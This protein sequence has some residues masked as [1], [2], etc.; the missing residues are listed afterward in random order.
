MATLGLR[1]CFTIGITIILSLPTVQTIYEVGWRQQDLVQPVSMVVEPLKLYLFIH[2]YNENDI[3]YFMDGDPEFILSVTGIFKPLCFNLEGKSG[4]I[5][6]LIQDGNTDISV[7]ARLISDNTSTFIGTVS[8][9][10]K[11]VIII[12]KPHIIIVNRE[13]F[14]WNNITAFLIRGHRVVI[15]MN[16]I[17]VTFRNLNVTAIVKRHETG[18][19]NGIESLSYLGFYLSDAR[20]FSPYTHGLLGQFLHKT[21]EIENL[22][23]RNNRAKAR[24]SITSPLNP[25]PRRA[26]AVLG[27]KMNR[28]LNTSTPCWVLRQDGRGVVDGRYNNYV[29]NSMRDISS[30]QLQ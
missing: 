26:M 28:A 14:Q 7:N 16:L 2:C 29:V 9:I 21:V 6:R 12:V 25:I 4:E 27:S 19:K 13:R 15:S 3:L 10:R 18:Q 17:A 1:L 20:G 11:N 22:R 8:I 30:L 24:L 5:I 23:Y